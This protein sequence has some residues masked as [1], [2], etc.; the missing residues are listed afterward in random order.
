MQLL[1]EKPAVKKQ[2]QDSRSLD[3]LFSAIVG[4]AHVDHVSSA[5]ESAAHRSLA[6]EQ[7]HD[8]TISA[9]DLMSSRVMIVDD[10]PINVKVA[11]KF[12]Q[13]LGYS[14]FVTLTDSRAVVEALQREAPDAL[15]L[16]LMMPDVSGLDILEVMQSDSKLSRIPV[17]V[18]TASSDRGTRLR[19]LELG[20]T[21]FLAKPLDPDELAP[22]L[23]NALLMR[24]YENHLRGHAETLELTVRHRT[25]D[26]CAARLELV[27]C[28][29]RAAEHRDDDTG[30]HILRVG[31][32]AALIAR[33]VGLPGPYIEML[34]L[35]AQL[36]D[37]G[38]IGL[39][40]AILLKPGRLT[41]EERSVME[42][43]TTVGADVLNSRSDMLGNVMIRH[44]EIGAQLTGS[45]RSPLT[46]L[47][48]SIA[49]T[50]HEK[51]DGSG[52]PN[53]LA[54]TDIPIEG[55]ITAIADVFDALRSKRPYK[56]PFSLDRSFDILL[57]GRGKH[58]DAELVD[59][60][61]AS[62]TEVEALDDELRND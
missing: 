10:E 23:R 50:H 61:L 62:R 3:D 16:D 53:G 1:D 9:N 49:L 37:V 33:K 47:A 14:N 57:K 34:E 19:A 21:D 25:R 4:Q 29:A 13:T 39:S 40:D 31:R 20:A 60:F 58:F 43:H 6:G 22:R 54:G 46:E 48:A 24:S 56:E 38:K 27:H 51:W 41:D 17:I 32:Y 18:L 30:K 7:S 36:H 52:Y 11:R 44:A 5:C 35:A 2:E 28:L 12:V 45:S 15:L 59:H 26:L 42:V 8:L 55:R